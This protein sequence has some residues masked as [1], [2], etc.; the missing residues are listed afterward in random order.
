MGEPVD[1]GP[2]KPGD[3]PSR[4]AREDAGRHNLRAITPA[5]RIHDNTPE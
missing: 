3:Q 1:D 4:R 2:L 5:L